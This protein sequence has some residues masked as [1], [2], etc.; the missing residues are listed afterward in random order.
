MI[1][2][3]HTLLDYVWLIW[4]WLFIQ[5][6]WLSFIKLQV[7]AAVAAVYGAEMTVLEAIECAKKYLSCFMDVNR[8]FQ[9][10]G[11][12]F[13]CHIYDDYAHHPTAICSTLQATRQIFP[14]QTL[15]VIFQPHTYRLLS[16]SP[17]PACFFLL[18]LPSL[19]KI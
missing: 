13:G 17:K 15:Y 3:C 6:I 4:F 7:I 9:L 5:S 8:R 10:V 2:S 12:I 11:K 18:M 1:V 16:F 19:Q 14:Y